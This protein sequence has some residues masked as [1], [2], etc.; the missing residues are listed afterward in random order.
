M[1]RFFVKVSRPKIRTIG[2]ME[3]FKF[4]IPRGGGICNSIIKGL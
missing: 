1:D 3:I 4:E 2:L